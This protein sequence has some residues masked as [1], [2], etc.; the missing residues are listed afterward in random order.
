[1]T[2]TTSTSQTGS[3]RVRTIGFIGSGNIGSALAR[4]ALGRGMDVVMS[5]SRG[6]ETLQAL[7]LELG[8]RARAATPAEAAAAGD[9]VVV[10]IPLKNFRAVP[11][12]EL[13]GKTVIDTMNY[14]P[15]RDGRI[16]EL[17]D[18]STT[19]SELLQA[20]LPDSQVVKAFNT[21][22]FE[23]LTSQGSA[24]G[25]PSRR[26]LPI[27]GDSAEAKKQVAALIHEFGFDVVDAGP[28]AEGWRFQPDTPSYVT[29]LDTD[30]L[31]EALAKAARTAGP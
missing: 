9:V 6:P 16:P 3:S 22:H 19:S 23:H 8:D 27:A 26:A 17:D 2:E 13:A 31:S 25:T 21:I 30:S 11:R 15:Q 24:P 28:L 29:A 5:N 1:M 4:L 12:A 20:Y 10:S 14:Y 7:L 18:E